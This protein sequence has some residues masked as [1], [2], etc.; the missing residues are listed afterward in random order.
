MRAAALLLALAL[1]ACSAPRAPLAPHLDYIWDGPIPEM[2][3]VWTV[4]E[5]PCG[6][7]SGRALVYGGEQCASGA[8][9][10]VALAI[11]E[12]PGVCHIIA[13]APRSAE[14]RQRIDILRHELAHCIPGNF[15]WHP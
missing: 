15:N 3:I 7:V 9:K 11:I 8:V 13:P 12:A 2:R 10:P 4:T 1:A 6:A 14:D 5:N